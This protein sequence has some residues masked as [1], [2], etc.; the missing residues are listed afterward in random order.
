MFT[1]KSIKPAKFKSSIFREEL[2]LA[3]E[4]MAPQIKKD[5]QKTSATWKEKPEFQAGVQIGR[6]AGIRGGPSTGVAVEVVTDN[7]IY[8]YIDEGTRVRY[9]TMTPDF[10]AKTKPKV[11]R[12][13]RGRGGLLFVNKK[14][15]RP[16][17]KAREFSKTIRKKWQPLFRD[18]MDFAMRNA[19]RKSGHSAKK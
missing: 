10:Q 12:S 8:G 14:R 4:K 16:G 1:F 11:I 18:Q 15:P 2:T 6:A 19:G 17:I 5:F 3:A 13:Y 9:A 7:A